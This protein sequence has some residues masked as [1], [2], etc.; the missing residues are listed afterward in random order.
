MKIIP[1]TEDYSVSPQ[2]LPED[3]ARAAALGYRS[4]MCNRPDD[5]DPGQPPFAEIAAAAGALGLAVA[6]VPVV[7]GSIE[8]TDVDDFRATIASLPGPV[9]A[10]CRSGARCQNLWRLSR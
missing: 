7:S 2:I 8:E 3:V 6:H 1:M 4:I 10:Y 5:E 9:L